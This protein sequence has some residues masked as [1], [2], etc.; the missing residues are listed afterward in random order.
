MKIVDAGP[1]SGIELTAFASTGVRH[2]RIHAG[3]DG[4][5]SAGLMHLAP[6]GRIGRHEATLPQVLAV[7]SGEGYVSGADGL[8]HPISAGQAA[9]WSPGEE[10]ET[11]SGGTGLTA[12]VVEAETPHT[13][14]LLG[15]VLHDEE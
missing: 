8:P 14:G 10:H 5:F 9:C 4:A 11:W 2:V 1:G 12:F 13:A 6:G 15:R 3:T 7:L